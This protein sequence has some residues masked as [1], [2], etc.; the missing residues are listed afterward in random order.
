MVPWLSDELLMLAVQMM[1]YC[2]TV[3]GVALTFWLVP[4]G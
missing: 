2:F 3:V 1:C 4:R